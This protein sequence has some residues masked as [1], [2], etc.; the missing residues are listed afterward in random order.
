MSLG[1]NR[2][3]FCVVVFSE[4]FLSS[5][6]IVPGQSSAAGSLGFFFRSQLPAL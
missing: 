3:I 6:S 1:S 4:T 2:T 5:I